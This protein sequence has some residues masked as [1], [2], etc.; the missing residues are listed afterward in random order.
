[1]GYITR[2]RGVSVHRKDCPNISELASELDGQERFIDVGW[3]TSEK[4]EYPVEIQIIATDRPG[5][6]TNITQKINDSNLSLL[7][8]N[9]RTNKEKLVTINMTLEIKDT[10][11]LKELIRGIKKY[12]GRY[13][14]I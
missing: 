11:Q 6:L 14:C 12:E 1:M 9:A 5:L 8:L 3:D 13:R 4:A 10:T 2:G 7:S